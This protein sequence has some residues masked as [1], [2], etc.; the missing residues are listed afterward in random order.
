[1]E[2]ILQSLEFGTMESEQMVALRGNGWRD[3]FREFHHQMH[4]NFPE[5]GRYP[6][7]WPALWI[8]TGWRFARNNRVVRRTTIKK[9][10]QNAKKRG[11]ISN[12]LHLFER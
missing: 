8:R 9:V 5:T 4:L 11:K 2:E 12:K 1:M 3:L 6:V 7:L 10:I